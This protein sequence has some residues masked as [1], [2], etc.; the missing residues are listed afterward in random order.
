[1]ELFFSHW[2]QFH[3]GFEVPE[4]E[5]QRNCVAAEHSTQTHTLMYIIKKYIYI[6]YTQY[7]ASVILNSFVEDGQPSHSYNEFRTT[8]TSSPIMFRA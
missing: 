5:V 2:M 3:P 4:M 7:C 8:V 6:R 1:M